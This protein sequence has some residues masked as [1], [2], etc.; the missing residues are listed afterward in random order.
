MSDIFD[1]RYEGKKV[2]IDD[3]LVRLGDDINLLGK[4]LT[5]RKIVIGAGWDLNA[6]G[7]DSLDIDL[8]VFLLD[9]NGQTRVDED[10]VFYNQKETLG[11]G[12]KH[13]GDSRTGAGDGD[14]E[15]IAI[16]LQSLPFDIMKVQIVISIYKGYEKEQHLSQVRNAYLRIVNADTKHEVCRYLLDE[17][18]ADHEETAVLIGA[19]NREGPK[20]HFKPEADFVEGGLGATAR[21]YGL[22]IKQE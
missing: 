19:L 15:S 13:G 17:V 20:W 9:K 21:R 5:L 18:L 2:Q 4:D 11:G 8:S 16:D 14:D 6:F 10:F 7:T 12:V 22:L 3:G 1:T